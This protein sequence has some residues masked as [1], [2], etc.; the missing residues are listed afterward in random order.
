MHGKRARRRWWLGLHA[1]AIVALALLLLGAEKPSGSVE[2]KQYQV[3]FIGSGA[4]GGGTL[5]FRG[6]EHEFTI[7]GLGI[8]GIG[9][10]SIDATGDVFHLEKLADFPGAYGQARAGIVVADKSKG[11]V[12]LK[13]PNG[14]YIRLSSDRDGVMLSLGADGVYIDLK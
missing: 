7:G 4:L 5:R 11:A 1:G 9:V 2:I 13:N 3:A 10:S 12:W 6:Q 14:V 8:G